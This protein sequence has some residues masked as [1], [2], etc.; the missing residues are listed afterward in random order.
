MTCIY[1]GSRFRDSLPGISSRKAQITSGEWLQGGPVFRKSGLIGSIV[2]KP[3]QLTEVTQVETFIRACGMIP[4]ELRVSTAKPATCSASLWDSSGLISSWD[5]SSMPGLIVTIREASGIEPG[6][7]ILKYLLTTP[8][9]ETAEKLLEKFQ[10]FSMQIACNIQGL[11][12]LQI[13]GYTEPPE[14]R[15]HSLQ[16]FSLRLIFS[17]QPYELYGLIKKTLSLWNKI[18]DPTTDELGQ[19]TAV[20]KLMELQHSNPFLA[21]LDWPAYE[22]L[23]VNYLLD[24]EYSP[25]TLLE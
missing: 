14:N 25:D 16:F 11:P 19:E 7:L 2:Q 20:T 18:N 8:N 1:I 12:F 9:I 6:N 15:K 17:H 4:V 24:R 22:G 21:E 23:L 5:K 13:T 3:L 10:N